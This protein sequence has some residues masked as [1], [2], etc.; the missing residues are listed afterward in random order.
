M[1]MVKV[2][3]EI[4]PIDPN[5]AVCSDDIISLMRIEK[6]TLKKLR[7]QGRLPFPDFYIGHRPRWYFKTIK[8]IM[9]KGLV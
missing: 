5:G 7:S 6:S 1:R 4:P 8:S 3:D 9:D 2:L